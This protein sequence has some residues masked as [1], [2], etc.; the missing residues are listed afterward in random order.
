MNRYKLISASQQVVSTIRTAR[1]QA[2]GKNRTHYVRFDYPAAGQYQVRKIEDDATEGDGGEV[3]EL[4]DDITFS[5]PTDLE[6]TTSGR[7]DAVAAVSIIVTD[8]NADFDR[9]ITV[10]TSGQVRLE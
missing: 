7:L 3:Q 9:T 8:G 10:S 5:E 4:P 1:I 6:F 2:V